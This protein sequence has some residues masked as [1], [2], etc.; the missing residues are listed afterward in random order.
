MAGPHRRSE[1][2]ESAVQQSALRP[3]RWCHRWRART[4]APS[5]N[6]RGRWSLRH[7][8][9]LCTNLLSNNIPE[10]ITF[11]EPDNFAECLADNDNSTKSW[12]D[13]VAVCFTIAEFR[14]D[15]FP[16][17]KFRADDVT[18]TLQ[19]AFDIALRKPE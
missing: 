12:P 5:S 4:V 14:T 16:C 19:C 6:G 8:E 7:D 17:S 2:A 18:P 11:S 3:E 9:D 13:N 10:S 15:G 1:R